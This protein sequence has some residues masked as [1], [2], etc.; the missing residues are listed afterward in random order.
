MTM[1]STP[2]LCWHLTALQVTTQVSTPPSYASNYTMS[3]G[4][5]VVAGDG[6]TLPISGAR[7]Y[8]WS[9]L[10]RMG[11]VG[12]SHTTHGHTCMHEQAL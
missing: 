4:W 6:T 7:N 1:I 2:H 12:G 8:L 10:S 11:W 3:T 5:L 9:S